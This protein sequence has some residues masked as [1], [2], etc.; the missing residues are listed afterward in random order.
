MLDL[1]PQNK[2]E[3]FLQL[4]QYKVCI[5][6]ITNKVSFDSA[7]ASLDF[8]DMDNVVMEAPKIVIYSEERSNC[9]YKS[10][11]LQIPISQKTKSGHVLVATIYRV[12]PKE[13]KVKR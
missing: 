11:A 2:Q 10:R 6:D 12:E 1:Y 13:K 4:K 8:V 7:L 9:T 5:K 3:S